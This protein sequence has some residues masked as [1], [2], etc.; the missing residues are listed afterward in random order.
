VPSNFPLAPT[1]ANRHHPVT[2]PAYAW[3]EKA[4]QQRPLGQLQIEVGTV[5]FF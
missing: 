2:G 1:G 5:F 3:A 4:D